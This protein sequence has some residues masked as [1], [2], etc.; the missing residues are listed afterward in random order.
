SRANETVEEHHN[1][2]QQDASAK[3]QQRSEETKEEHHQRNEHDAEAHH[4]RCINNPRL[5]K[6]AYEFSKISS[7]YSMPHRINAMNYINCFYH[8]AL[9]LPSESPGMCCSNRKVILS[10]PVIPL[11]LQQLFSNKDDYNREFLS[12]ICLYNAAFTFISIDVKFD[13]E[14]TN[15]RDG[16]YT[17]FVQDDFS[18]E[19]NLDNSRENYIKYN[20]SQQ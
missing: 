12:K 20:D 11:F 6:L 15:S 5:H 18:H 4:Y 3:H 7:N 9:K 2:Q 10:E 14:L 8:N 13:Y 19:P 16:I 1:C 17:Y